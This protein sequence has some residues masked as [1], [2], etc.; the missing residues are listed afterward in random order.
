VVGETFVSRSGEIRR[1]LGDTEGERMK[2]RKRTFY[3]QIVDVCDAG[4]PGL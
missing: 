1:L 2:L 4:L 3:F